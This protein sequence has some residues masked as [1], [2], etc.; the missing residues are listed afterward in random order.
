MRVMALSGLM[1]FLSPLLS[2][3]L[4]TSSNTGYAS[5]THEEDSLVDF[6]LVDLRITEDFLDGHEGTTEENLTKFRG[7][8]WECDQ[9]RCLG[10]DQ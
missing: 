7:W 5:E 9:L 10:Q 1:Y 2:K 4:D 3:K 8:I 6:S